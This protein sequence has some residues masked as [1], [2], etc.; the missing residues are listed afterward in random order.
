MSS[1]KQARPDV[2]KTFILSAVSAALMGAGFGAAAQTPT[3][4]DA[5]VRGG[6]AAITAILNGLQ[7]NQTTD[8]AFIDWQKFGVSA[9]DL[10]QFI[11]NN[12][13]SIAVNRVTGPAASEIMGQLKANG[14]LFLLNPNG[15]LI[16]AGAEINVGSLL[17][18][19]LKLSDDSQGA[20][21]AFIA[22]GSQLAFSDTAAG[23][24]I[25]NNGKIT[26][27]D[28]GFVYLVATS[29][30]NNGEIVA[31]L[32]K[33]TLAA[34]NKAT[35]DLTGNNLINLSADALTATGTTGTGGTKA[36]VTN[37][38]TG[39]ITAG[40]VALTANQVSGLM[41]SLVSNEGVVEATSLVDVKGAEIAQ[42]GKIQGLT[43]GQDV[44][45][46]NTNLVATDSITTGADSVT[47]A[48]DLRL[49]V[50]GAGKSVGAEGQALRVDAVTLT[51]KA[52]SGHVIVTDTDGGVALKE[53]TTGVVDGDTQYRAIITARNGAMTGL[54]GA[55]NVTAWGA[56]LVSDQSIGTD[57]QA[58]S[59]SV[60]SL[61]ASTQDGSINIANTGGDLVLGAMS[62]G[63]M[64]SINGSNSSLLPIAQADGTVTLSNGDP[65]TTKIRLKSDG[66]VTL[67]GAL[68]AGAEIALETTGGSIVTTVA[69]N[70]SET[71]ASA[72]AAAT[73]TAKRVD[74]KASGAIGSAGSAAQLRTESVAA[75]AG[76]GGVHLSDNNGL[77][78]ESITAQGT[79]NDVSVD[80]TQGNLRL[81][82][83]DA[84]GGNVTLGAAQGSISDN[85][86]DANNVTADTLEMR[87]RNDIGAA[88]NRL[89]TSVRGLTTA[90]TA[91]TAGTY[92]ANDRALEDL[93]AT[94]VRGTVAVSY[95]GG[96]TKYDSATRQLSAGGTLQNLSLTAKDAIDL[97]GDITAAKSLTLSALGSITQETG[98]L[99]TAEKIGATATGAITFDRTAA[100]YIKGAAGNG[101]FTV[102]QNT[103]A[104]LTLDATTAGATGDVT[105][106]NTSGDLVI[107][108]VNATRNVSLTAAGSVQTAEDRRISG[109]AITVSGSSLGSADR[110][111][112]T[113]TTGA[114]N[115][116][117][118][119]GNI[120]AANIGSLARLDAIANGAN[121]TIDLN[122]S[123]D[124][125]IGVLQAGGAINLTM[126]GG[127]TRASGS[128]AQNI[129]TGTLTANTR[130]FGQNG[131]ANAI[132]MQVDK[133]VIDTINGGIYV[134]NNGNRPLLIERATSAGSDGNISIANGGGANAGIQVKKIT[135]GSST[136]TLASTGSI[137]D[138]RT[139][140][141]AANISAGRLNVSAD[142]GVGN[143]G[144][145]AL[146]VNY[147]AASG[148]SGAV[149]AAN[150]GAIIVDADSL[151]G[152]GAS[153]VSITATDIT[154]LNQNGGT[155]QMDTGGSL[156]LIATVGHIVF[157]NTADTIE[158]WADA[159]GNGGDVTMS[160]LGESRLGYLGAIVAGNVRTHG[161]DIRLEA[162]SNISIGLLDAGTTGDVTVIA[163]KGIIIDGNGTTENIR[164]NV[165]TLEAH[166][167]DLE[168]AKYVRE[169][170]GNNHDQKVAEV[171]STQTVYDVYEAE[172]RTYQRALVEAQQKL[173]QAQANA[174]ATQK[175]VNDLQAEVDALS[176]TFQ[177]LND[178]LTAAGIAKDAAS[179]A[180]AGAQAIPFSGDGGADLVFAG[181]DL[182]L[183]VAQTAVD[184]FQR[185]TLD[186]KE[187][188]LADM[189][190]QLDQALAGV[191]SSLGDMLKAQLDRDV[192]ATSYNTLGV[193][194]YRA[195][196]ARDAALKVLE[197][198]QTAVVLNKDIDSSAAKPLGISANQL[199]INGTLNTD[200][201]LKSDS[202]LGLGNIAVASGKVIDAYAANNIGVV[203]N[204]SSDKS[205]TL[206][207]RGDIVGQ[208]GKLIS[209]LVSL[210]AGRSI[211]GDVDANPLTDNTVF[212]QTSTL[213]AQAADGGAYISNANG[214]ALLTIGTAGAVSGVT[215][216]DSITLATD[217]DLAVDE[218]IAGG[219]KTTDTVR[220][221]SGGAIT[222]GQ[223]DV[224]DVSGHRLEIVAKGNATLDTNVRQLAAGIDVPGNL[225]VVNTGGD[226]LADEVALLDGNASIKTEGNM[227]VGQ[228]SLQGANRTATLEAS[229]GISR[230]LGRTVA[231]S[232]I[233]ADNL[234]LKAGSY[235]GD[236]G[237]T[238]DQ[239]RIRVS[240]NNL[241]AT[242]SG[243]IDIIEAGNAELTD[244]EL[245]VKRVA[246]TEGNVSLVS[247][248]NMNV[249]TIEA[250]GA[251]KGVVLAAVDGQ[252]LNARTDA[253]ANITAS[254]LAMRGHQGIGGTKALNVNVATLAADGGTGGIAVN[255]LTGDLT[256]G[257]LA[258]A[259]E[260]FSDV[261][262]PPP[263]AP[264]TD[265]VIGLQAT[266]DIDVT[267]LGGKMTVSNAVATTGS[268]DLAG[269][270]SL[271]AATGLT[272]D[273][274]VTAD[275]GDIALGTTRGALAQN[276]DITATAGKVDLSATTGN[277]SSANRTGNIT[278]AAGTRTTAGA[279]VNYVADAN[280]TTRAIQAGTGIGVKSNTGNVLQQGTL[281]SDAG[282]I[283]LSSGS[284]GGVTQNADT[285]ATAGN[286]SV[287]GGSQG[288]TM[289]AGTT[290]SAG[291][292]KT[293]AYT[294]DGNIAARTLTAGS[295]VNVTSNNGSVTQFNTITSTAGNIALASGSAGGVTQNANTTATAGNV[296]VTGGSQGITMAAGTTTSAGA[297][298]TIAYTADG[299]VSTQVLTAGGN[300][301]VTS[302]DGGIT[303]NAAITSATGNVALAALNGGISQQAN[304][305]ATAGSVQVRAGLDGIT[306]AQGTRSVAG[307]NGTLAYDASGN[308]LT[309][310]LQAGRNVDVKST[311]G[312]V[313]LQDQVQ[314]ATGDVT[315]S[316][317]KH[318]AQNAH[319]TATTGNVSVTG[320][321]E[322]ITMA[323]GTR[324][325]AGAARSVTYKAQGNIAVNDIRT[326]GGNVAL[327]SDAGAI[328]ANAGV[329]QHVQAATLNAK[330]ATGIGA[331]GSM[332]NTSVNQLTAENTGAGDINVSEADAISLEKL[333]A[334]NGSVYLSAGGNISA[335]DVRAT[336]GTADLYSD[337][338]IEMG[339]ADGR[340]QADTLTLTAQNGIDAATRANTINAN[341]YGGGATIAL[342]DSGSATLRSVRTDSGDIAV[343][344]AGSIDVQ[345]VNAGYGANNVSL[346]AGEA[347]TQGQARN[348]VLNRVAVLSLPVSQANV[349]ANN[350]QLSA[351]TGIGNGERGALVTDVKTIDASTATGNASIDQAN[352]VTVSN[353]STGGGDATLVV[354]Q[355]DA[356]VGNVSATGTAMLTTEAGSQ[357][358]DGNADTRIVAD[359]ANLT[360]SGNVNAGTRVN[361]LTANGQAITIDEQDGLARLTATASNGDVNVTSRT[362]DV[363]VDQVNAGTQT[364]SINAVQGSIRNAVQGSSAITAQNVLLN[365]GVGLGDA[366][367]ALNLRTNAVSAQAGNGGAQL[368]NLNQG[369]LSLG[370]T[371]AT[372]G[373]VVVNTAGQLAVD[374]NVSNTGGGDITLQAAGDV[375]QS[376]N[377]VATRSGNVTVNSGGNIDM[378]NSAKTSSG[379]GDITYAAANTVTVNSISTGQGGNVGTVTLRGQNV[380]NGNT[381]G[382]AVEGRVVNID[383]PNANADLASSLLGDT[384]Q[385]TV[386]RF[387][388]LPV[389]GTLVEG[390]RF[391]NELIQA[392]EVFKPG[393][394]NQLND[395]IKQD[396]LNPRP[397]G[398]TL[399]EVS[400]F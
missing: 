105:L 175:E 268:D 103:A 94:T 311:G 143:N 160:A 82:S 244:R 379:T 231:S 53:V 384:R 342:R 165:V 64:V 353:L 199:N 243:N 261:P 274:A 326:T 106:G 38:A 46:V 263:L 20:I 25:T 95:T 85:N 125:A 131:D 348:N 145:L 42:N 266:G 33:V 18:T 334:A 133:L 372:G 365:A 142:R 247:T 219:N 294:A 114:L 242:G 188:E 257:Q 380:V 252:I 248:G 87:A 132:Q 24:K 126:V 249:D 69:S 35:I 321:A 92:I 146:N 194:L 370:N 171:N 286:V 346:Q 191:T 6:N 235:I 309:Y 130:S 209:P 208:G 117:A 352:A 63:Q 196:I 121:T 112:G 13:N 312:D 159:Q 5:T 279:A 151:Q 57:G 234:V 27:A 32:G 75:T 258:R 155:I 360:A 37:T 48:N 297:G 271:Q 128:P 19:T 210:I 67:G 287:T 65:G 169:T 179:F 368:N 201:Y 236:T 91:T 9:G 354:R 55:T 49:E 108:N 26:A 237:V 343:S 137:E 134:V 44:G 358:D 310:G 184:V 359:S 34:G 398:K 50:T 228:V 300:I 383:S 122:L 127:A 212:T 43:V 291:A 276:A 135:A 45:R 264:V 397:M 363:I 344:A 289:A 187:G 168:D 396:P 295:D 68:A 338:R 182:A 56:N 172:L 259:N 72:N 162:A 335:K 223:D 267:A 149:H 322:G 220:L 111:L 325:T 224:A 213:A 96:E 238:S 21:D 272:Q 253:Q 90:T 296:S 81:G 288:I 216:A 206:N 304:T 385:L 339:S 152:K 60:R 391:S 316:A 374:G 362:G 306:M 320:G 284:A 52:A 144:E 336:Q 119:D 110:A 167:P 154:I 393:I 217:G 180:A 74:L 394:V 102:A 120:N 246:T 333:I 364:A 349:V 366:N 388:D 376:G 230:D 156:E 211:G 62:A 250:S 299:N 357:Q 277:A 30:D 195:Q 101:A 307:T 262:P 392:Q 31:Q 229:E 115:L 71:N 153:K 292:G 275:R 308:V 317:S 200:L 331:G 399:I 303:Q 109:A 98:T 189:N 323:E 204:V 222:N 256:I 221:V 176:A 305:Q 16:G 315:V 218:A 66:N 116:T 170:M 240:A 351:G 29:V 54:S 387:S 337:G 181:I 192:T 86:G 371:S 390:G 327:T 1:K 124:A 355:G 78:V 273:A 161:G 255:D 293:I 314:S 157:L 373:N 77:T 58:V 203:G 389:G 12:A 148:G 178:V 47:K 84:A 136:V 10:V 8:R 166:T 382:N 225:T 318:V 207:A 395:S 174:N 107:D 138:A 386:V 51:A 183:S 281:T 129:I 123:G 197:Q 254:T 285:T 141:T 319:V 104:T 23:Q 345:S 202:N 269:N 377:V 36:G 270:I 375:R 214:G 59:T 17:A 332:L 164:G 340:I 265:D 198:S 113:T 205:I 76:N 99:V 80:V 245:T 28:N 41:S 61:A 163:R 400:G 185:L 83:I 93:D 233:S 301:N 11:Q 302:N 147:L 313:T 140:K 177:A 4:G 73:L 88:S 381:S 14:K 158:L 251:G 369:T 186:P 97:R 150:T 341:A 367:G 278:M 350:L 70:D 329:G 22:N 139:D 15:I 190:N 7:I 193:A 260:A 298:K 347:I 173:A 40:T 2:R 118:T 89:E 39:K 227:T 100:S 215:A 232:Y 290:T 239:D 226:L 378:A 330:A 79:G 241:T 328:L 324:T 282:D 283:L 3:V 361:T 356:T 280:I